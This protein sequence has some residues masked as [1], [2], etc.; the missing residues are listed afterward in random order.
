MATLFEYVDESG[1]DTG[2]L[3]FVVSMVILGTERAEALKVLEKIERQTQ[4][5]NRKW[6]GSD[7]RYRQAYI[8]RIA[9]LSILK[10]KIFYETFTANKEYLA[11]TASAAADALREYGAHDPVIVFVDGL[12]ESAIAKFKRQI[13]PSIRI[14]IKVRGVRKDENN[15]FIRLVDAICGMVRDAYTNQKWAL[16]TLQLLKQKGI[17]TEL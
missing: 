13:K 12:R 3:F 8:E 10:A 14:S 17:L 16:K 9:H 5:E 6:N 11:M 7:P 2:G 1:Q 4:K 15:A